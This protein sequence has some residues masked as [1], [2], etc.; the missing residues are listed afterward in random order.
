[1]AAKLLSTLISKGSNATQELEAFMPVERALEVGNTGLGLTKT[2][3]TLLCIIITAI[4]STLVV[5]TLSLCL[6]N[7]FNNQPYSVF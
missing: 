7:T 2:A 1:M 4:H 5:I 3:C 6:D